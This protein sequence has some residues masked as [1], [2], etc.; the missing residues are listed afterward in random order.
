MGRPTSTA[1]F[2]VPLDRLQPF[3]QPFM[4][5]GYAGIVPG[6]YRSIEAHVLASVTPAVRTASLDQFYASREGVN[7]RFESLNRKLPVS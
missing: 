7:P 6:C 1:D 5:I 4:E 3:V 2:S